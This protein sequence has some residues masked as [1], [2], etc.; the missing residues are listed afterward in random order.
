LNTYSYALQ[1]PNR[2]VDPDGLFVVNPITV[3]IANGAINTVAGIIILY[4]HNASAIDPSLGDQ[5]LS[6]SG[7]PNPT[8]PDNA[9]VSDRGIPYDPNTAKPLACDAGWEDRCK[10]L[11]KE[12]NNVLFSEKSGVG[13]RRGLADRHF[14]QLGDPNGWFESADPRWGTHAGNI[15]SDRRYL[16]ALIRRAEQLGCAVPPEAYTFLR[17]GPPQRPWRYPNPYGD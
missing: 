15:F 6:L 3:Q 13:G 10:E 4:N 1:N 16:R 12:I 17:L 8:Y 11:I 9:R 2:F 7:L 5:P 14:Q